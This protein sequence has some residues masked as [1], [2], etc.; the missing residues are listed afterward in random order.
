MKNNLYLFSLSVLLFT[1]CHK[2]DKTDP[3][4]TATG[5]A[6]A[7]GKQLSATDSLSK[8]N[9]YFKTGTFTD[10]DVA[11]GITVFAP[12]NSAFGSLSVQTGE[13]FP[14]SSQLK[15][16]VVRGL[17]K[18][19][20]LTNGKTFTTIS[21]K[22]LTV[23]VSGNTVKVNGVAIN[24]ISAYTG[25]G[26]IIY[27]AMNLLNAAAPFSYTVW[28][29]TQW[30]A[31]QT[32]GVLASGATV[33]LYN[34]QA[35]YAAGVTAVYSIQT[36]SDGVATFNGIKPGAYYVVA[37]KGPINNVFKVYAE[38]VNQ[39][40]LGYFPD[41]VMDNQGNIKWKDLNADGVID[42]NDMGALPSLHVEAAK[43]T[44]A[45]GTILMGYVT[46]PLPTA[47]DAQTILNGAY[48]SLT[49]TAAYSGMVIIDGM[50]SDDAVCGSKTAYCPFDNFTV[51]AT[52]NSISTLWSTL[53]G[54]IGS[55]NRVVND[56]PG[57][58]I[59]ADQKVDL[60]AQAKG[61]RAYIYLV[62]G[63][64]FGNLPIHKNITSTLFP[65]ISRST[66]TEVY[67][68]I[69]SDLTAAAADLPATRPDGK[70]SLT[71]NAAL[72]LLARAALW[73]REYATV[74]TYTAQII[75]GNVYSLSA[76]NSWLTS[77][78]NAEAI[79]A[80]AFSNMNVLTSWYFA[81][82]TPPTTVSVCP[83]LRY[84]HILLM[85]AEAQINLG[86]LSAAGDDLFALKRDD[87]AAHYSFADRS[88]ADTELQT[89][90]QKENKLQGD[91]FLNLVRWDIAS[92]TL[93]PN[94]FDLGKSN[95]LPIPQSFLNK[96]PALNQN[97]GY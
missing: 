13:F 53:Y 49:M 36:G 75:S 61:L 72:G 50:L 80:P 42:A 41:T 25:E 8:F 2:K 97:P 22:T 20:D 51:T 15:D 19:A 18:T 4:P 29:A 48:S 67:N 37:S 23:S 57:L 63:E 12:A 38:T 30:T 68:A 95:L 9:N 62:M 54:L 32:R 82:I 6:A 43:E 87:Q 21:G 46:K 52:D 69:V 27:S 11:G 66:S 93:A 56:V 39:A 59:A 74:H 78:T 28:D 88:A 86:N 76:F 34:S 40:Y 84:G 17:I 5:V 31:S 96:Y 89:V 10:Q 81:G 58:N 90:W 47:S 77:A 35:D 16:Y 7:V 91:R 45:G 73:Q 64:Y 85:D 70:L 92:Q 71:K 44:A 26:F 65:G 79:W 1:A 83:V 14:D 24:T 94:G 33:A 55:L 60:V 3:P